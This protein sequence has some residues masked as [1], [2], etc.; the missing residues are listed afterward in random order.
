[1]ETRS[2]KWCGS[3]FEV[4]RTTSQQLFCS[5]NCKGSFGNKA[6]RD[7]ERSHRPT[8]CAE[9][10]GPLVQ[11]AKGAPKK[12]CSAA[13][14]RRAGNRRVNRSLMPLAQ[15]T[16]RTC[17]HCGKA[18]TAKSRDRIYCYDGWCRQAAY[19]ARRKTGAAR[20]VGEHEV[21]CDECNTLFTAKY[22]SARWCSKLC[23][24]RYWGRMRA[25]QRRVRTEANYTDLEVFER[26]GWRC[27]ICGDLIDWTAPRTSPL[28]ATIDHIVP[29]S[30]GGADDL[31]NV[32]AA[33]HQCNIAKGNR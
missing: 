14:K 2:C 30:K 18:F 32:A 9:C 29:L 4:A 26:D 16:S 20:L 13:C 19:H 15:P 31:G 21:S 27:H 24:N 28:G 17:A 5:H 33:H 8:A 12:Y 25:R 23:A 7:K 1:M 6:A 10:A 3:S 22:P 11:P